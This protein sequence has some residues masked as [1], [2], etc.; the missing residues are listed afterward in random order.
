MK[1]IQSTLKNNLTHSA[2][3][4][5]SLKVG[6]YLFFDIY[7]KRDNNYLIIIESGTVLTQALYE[8]LLKQ[9]RLFIKKEDLHRQK[10]T[11]SSLK[12]YITKSQNNIEKTLEFLYTIN[13][14]I[15][16]EYLHSNNNKIDIVCVNA[17]VESI[18]YL[19]SKDK[20]YLKKAIPY[21]VNKHELATHSLHVAI[22]SITIGSSYNLDIKQLLKLGI[23]GLLHDV[24]LK[25]IDNSIIHKDSKLT[26]VELETIQQHPSHSVEILK[27]NS[28]HD[29]YIIN[30]IMHHH[31]NYDG[32]GYPNALIGDDISDFASIIS[33]ADVFDALTNARPNREAY[34]SFKALT[35][36]MKDELMVNKFNYK[37]LQLFL[38]SL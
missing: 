32:T 12:H 36:M 8:K 20:G 11:C 16:A 13:E 21:F 10:L 6:E 33:I 17:L 29:P 9:K 31:E 30:G 4:L 3:T 24:G 19:I 1:I 7:I 5:E 35:I 15:F 23:S 38:K 37:F 14:K 34:K 25:K 18:I 2:L 27:H 22:Y 28:I 26:L